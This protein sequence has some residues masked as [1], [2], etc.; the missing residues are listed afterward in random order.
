MQIY[1]ISDVFNESKVPVLTFVEPLEFPDIV[2][3]ILTNPKIFAGK[4]TLEESPS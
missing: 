1:N 4:H 3:S 2:G